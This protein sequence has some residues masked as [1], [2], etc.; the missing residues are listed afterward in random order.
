M[1]GAEILV[2][3][4]LAQGIDICFANPGTSE[5]HF[6]AALDRCQ[7]MRC[8]LGLFEGVVTGAADGYYRMVERPASTLLHLGPGLGNGLANLHNAKK[9]QSG[10]VNIVGQHVTSHIRFNAPLTADIEG[11]ARPVSAW[12][13]TAPDAASIA[14][15]ALE[16]IAAASGVPPAIATL[17]LPGDA[18]WGTAEFVAANVPSHRPKPVPAETIERAARLLK[19]GEP[20]LVILG[21]SALKG[22]A[23]DFAGR[24]AGR[25]G[26]RIATQFFSARIE[27]GA[28]RVP[29]ER[30]PYAV[31]L[32]IAMLK[33]FRHIITVNTSEPIAFFAYPNKPSQLK[34]EGC[35]VFALCADDEDSTQ[36]LS[37]LAAAVNAGPG[38]RL[39]QLAAAKDRP[40]GAL[41]SERV[42]RA[43]LATIP[44]GCI[45]VDESVTTGRESFAVTAGAA[46][47]DTL[48]N[49]GGAI[50]FG[51]PVSVGAAIACPDR[52]VLCVVG[53]GSAMYTLQSLWTQARESLNVVTVVFANR[54]YQIL[55]NEFGAVGAGVPGPNA[56]S[57]LDI[58]NP[59]LDFLALAKG[60]GVSGARV[61]TADALCREIERGF[62]ARGPY[63]IEAQL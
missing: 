30:I 25:T 2:Q 58:D 15:L 62:A 60:M 3:T 24:I 27:R 37:D 46:P 43:L 52:P 23:L 34:P 47:H 44:E 48:Q 8:V 29:L 57:M 33:P 22:P 56:L 19:S 10:I 11:I 53:D 7:G 6:V 32:A 5:M 13:R 21:G 42:A 26:C 18:A 16:A 36:A 17:I 1:N 4:L 63:L 61:E 31:D 35:E 28:G 49:M 41:D 55:R 20:T 39:V 14:G 38:D 45:L 12:V 51:T 40:T 54:K 50:G 59:T 9:A